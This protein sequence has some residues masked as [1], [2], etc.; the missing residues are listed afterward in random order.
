MSPDKPS[1]SLS[2]GLPVEDLPW[3]VVDLEGSLFKPA[4]AVDIQIV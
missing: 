1:E 2:R 3:A 4:R